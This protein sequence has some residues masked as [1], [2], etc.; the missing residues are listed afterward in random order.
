MKVR[1][2]RTVPYGRVREEKNPSG[3]FD[4]PNPP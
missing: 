1:E 2:S 4:F 3:F